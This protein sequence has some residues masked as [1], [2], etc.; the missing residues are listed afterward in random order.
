MYSDSCRRDLEARGTK[1]HPAPGKGSSADTG[2]E[3]TNDGMAPVLQAQGPKPAEAP[4]IV[5]SAFDVQCDAIIGEALFDADG[6]TLA[7]AEDKIRGDIAV[8]PLSWSSFLATLQYAKQTY[9]EE[10]AQVTGHAACEVRAMLARLG[11]PASWPFLQRS[12]QHTDQQTIGA[13][14]D[15]ENIIRRAKV[16]PD[17][18]PPRVAR[19]VGRHCILLHLYSGRR[20]FGDLQFYLDRAPLPEGVT[21]HTVSLD[22][23]VDA[24]M[25]DVTKPSTRRF[26]LRSIRSKWTLG[27][28]TGPPCESWSVARSKQIHGAKFC[29]RVIRTMLDIWGVPSTSIR[30]SAQLQTGNDLLQFGVEGLFEL[31]MHG[32]FGALEHPAEPEE[33][34]AASIWRTVVIRFM[35]QLPEIELIRVIQGKLGAFSTKPTDLL[36]VRMPTLADCLRHWELTLKAPTAVSIGINH[37]GEFNTS[38]LK[39]YPPAMNRAISASFLSAI[40]QL[41]ISTEFSMPS[42]FLRLCKGMAISLNTEIE[43]HMG[44]DYAG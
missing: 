13:R 27:L 37:R 44:K 33:P 5:C 10:E 38:R 7:D 2:N 1:C 28:F 40:A 21:L 42:A 8:L 32:G 18:Q 3:R 20:R 16:T 36:A 9:G 4:N 11:D 26:W 6:Y 39:E 15:A 35:L 29:P 17:N 31:Y 12:Q 30:E 19:A 41:P 34:E 43:C 25:G 14:T 24:D 23:V 22:I